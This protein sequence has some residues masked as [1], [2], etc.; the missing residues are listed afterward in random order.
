MAPSTDHRHASEE[1]LRRLAGAALDATLGAVRSHLL[2]GCP[3]CAGELRRLLA[4]EADALGRLTAAWVLSEEEPAPRLVAGMTDRLYAWSL[5]FEA[6]ERA[7]GDLADELLRLPSAERADLARESWRYRSM[8][9]ARHLAERARAAVFDDPGQAVELGRLAAAMADRLA[10][11]G[12]PAGLAHDT[13]A[14]AWGA[15]ANA[16][17][18][19]SDLLEADR[20]M[21]VATGAVR[22]GSGHPLVEAEVLSLVGSLRRDQVRYDEARRGLERAVEVYQQH[23]PQ[24][25]LGRALLKLAQVLTQDGESERAVELLKEARGLLPEED[26]RMRLLAGYS[27]AVA[28]NDAGRASEARSYVEELEPEYKRFGGDPWMAQRWSWL[29]GWI[30]VSHGESDQAER[31]FR[32]LRQGCAERESAYEYALATLELACVLLDQGK[33]D[34]VGALAEEMVPLFA[35]R[36]I[37][38]HAL[39]ALALFQAA[40]AGRRATTELTRRVLRYLERARNNPHL[41]LSP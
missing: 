20:A 11:L 21:A 40:A 5:L 32:E 41:K 36:R 27:L 19:D 30:A 24:G 14:L 28:L 13:R 2:E 15:L 12:Y 1:E 33:V 7:A 37:H 26:G 4:E 16:L 9:L 8:A 17:R 3:R 10:E 23:G 38:R 29:A 31:L 22:A 25:L 39:A 35:S 18:V 34:E 6:E